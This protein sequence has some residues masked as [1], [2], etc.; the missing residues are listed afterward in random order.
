MV[1]DTPMPA[2]NRDRLE[3]RKVSGQPDQ[4]SRIK[5]AGSSQ[6]DQASRIKPAGSSQPDQA[7]RIKP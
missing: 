4:A 6:P 3:H 2:V 5:P 7:S 1:G